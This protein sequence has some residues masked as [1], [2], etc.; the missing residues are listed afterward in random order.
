MRGSAPLSSRTSSRHS[1]RPASTWRHGWPRPYAGGC[2]ARRL[3]TGGCIR[4]A[5]P[6]AVC[7]VCGSDNRTSARFCDTCGSALEAPVETHEQRKTVTVLFCD[8]VG[9][10]ALGE[11]ADPE[12]L[13][14]LLA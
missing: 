3:A 1:P 12:A 7:V 11:S 2:R 13:R 5:S 9:S 6:M 14:A 4:Q 8:V 10:T